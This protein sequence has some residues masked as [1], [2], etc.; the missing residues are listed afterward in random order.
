VVDREQLEQI[1]AFAARHNLWVISDEAYDGLTYDGCEHVSIAALDGMFDRT[2]S[3][4][5]FSKVYMFSGLRLGYVVANDDVLRTINKIMVH[6]LYGPATVSQ[7][8]MV[9]PVRSRRRWRDAFIDESRRMRDRFLDLLAFDVR[10]PQGTYYVFFPATAFL[11]GRDYW[12]LIEACLDAGVAVAPGKDFG[13]GYEE[14]IRLCFTGEPPERV[15]LAAKRL[16]SV[17]GL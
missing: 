11:D 14:W 5:T 4:F 8:M 10:V 17:L 15:E 6:Q 13:E 9:E 3:F 7:M 2:L 1:A 12:D 16:N